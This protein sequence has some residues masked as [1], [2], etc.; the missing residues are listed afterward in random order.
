MAVVISN[1]GRLISDL[2][3]VA[4][5]NG[6]DLFIVQSINATT[7]A[8]RKVQLSQLSTYVLSTLGSLSSQVILQNAS[9]EF[10]GAFYNANGYGSNLYDVTIRNSLTISA[11]ASVTLSP[12]NL[13][14]GPSNGTLFTQK[15]RNTVGGITGSAATG[16]TG[17]LKGKLTGNVVG[18]VTGNVTGNVNGNLTGNVIGTITG[19][20]YGDFVG[21]VYNSSGNKA[22]E[23]GTTANPGGNIPN[24][25]FYGT[26]SYASQALTAAYA[27]AGAGGLPGGGNQ[28][29]VATKDGSGGTI[30]STPITRSGAPTTNYLSYWT[31]NKTLAGSNILYNSSENKIYISNGGIQV[32]NGGTSGGITGSFYGTNFKTLNGKSVSLWATSSHAVSASYATNLAPFESSLISIPSAGNNGEATHGLAGVPKTVRWVYKNTTAG[33][34]FGV[35]AGGEIDASS[36]WWAVGGSSEEA[37]GVNSLFWA[38]STKCYIASYQTLLGPYIRVASDTGKFTANTLTSPDWKLKCYATY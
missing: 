9:N 26:S 11:G 32:S 5:L 20:S 16:F 36:V 19:T 34:L 6:G 35:A 31:D 23:S 22:L 38:D 21:D 29:Q 12:T 13:T 27:A 1:R 24:A 10:T 18:D 37:W 3:Q 8:T 14:I 25:F 2:T 30:W 15:V 28:Y 33:T 4:S 7:N 17:S